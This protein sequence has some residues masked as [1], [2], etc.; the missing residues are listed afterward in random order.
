MHIHTHTHTHTHIYIF[1]LGALC[2]RNIEAD[3]NRIQAHKT[4][5]LSTPVLYKVS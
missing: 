5:F 4:A 2:Y 1:Q 3:Y